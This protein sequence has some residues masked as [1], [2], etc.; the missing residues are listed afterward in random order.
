MSD[1]YSMTKRAMIRNEIYSLGIGAKFTAG[2]IRELLA[3]KGVDM[4]PHAT[5]AVLRR[6]KDKHVRVVKKNRHSG[7]EYEVVSIPK[8]IGKIPKPT[9]N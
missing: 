4:D 1:M 3:K 6:D 7:C 9:H 2:T 5:T 8:H